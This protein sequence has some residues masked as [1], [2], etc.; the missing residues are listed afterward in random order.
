L[1]PY[2][3]VARIAFKVGGFTSLR[4]PTLEGRPPFVSSTGTATPARPGET[5]PP[6]RVL[7]LSESAGLAAVLGGLL[8][9]DDRLTRVGSLREAADGGRLAGA[10]AVVLDTPADG[11]ATALEHLR[12]Q[13]RGPLVVLVERGAEGR[14]LP[15][16]QARTLLVRPFAAD[17][18]G[19][20]LGL[21]A[22]VR[23]RHELPRPPGTAG[24]A[25]PAVAP[26]LPAAG[27]IV[28]ATPP[29]GPGGPASPPPGGGSAAPG[30]VVTFDLVAAR[31]AL[32]RQGGW[33]DVAAPGGSPWRRAR[34]RIEL[35]PDDLVHAW[36]ARR[37]MRV[38]G[39]W[40]VCVAAFLVAFVLAAQD[41]SL[42]S[43]E[44]TPLPTVEV[45]PAAPPTTAARLPGTTA[46][47]AGAPGG[48]DFR[49]ASEGILG[50]TTS[51]ARATT[52]TRR[53]A[54]GG[55][56]TRPPTTRPTTSTAGEATTTT[57]DQ[58]TT[59]DTTVAGP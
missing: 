43:V 16:D 2:R 52:T 19:A 11:R 36:R 56:T 46:G 37:W 24:E 59:T 21:P 29:D 30:T 34:H 49:G 6:E 47:G 4:S 12:R 9:G 3:L 44:V 22:A 38:A 14:K 20:A 35:L 51:A 15:P 7:L 41:D 53:P 26:P 8:D 58:V 1:H 48:G 42:G 45:E 13:Y 54:P 10:D 18:L 55:A 50:S 31:Q 28:H 39:F 32:Q 5:R 27:S 17:D 23:Q 33:P 40:A 25:T 57:S